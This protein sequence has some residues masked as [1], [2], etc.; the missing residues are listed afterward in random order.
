MSA[1]HLNILSIFLFF[2]RGSPFCHV[3]SVL[4]LSPRHLPYTIR[5]TSGDATA[6]GG[7]GKEGGADLWGCYRCA[8]LSYVSDPGLLTHVFSVVNAPVQKVSDQRVQKVPS[9]ASESS[10]FTVQ[11][12]GF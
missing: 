11:S 8:R 6:R 3:P 9:D 5:H 7:L 4:P 12:L 2:S 1:I 10:G